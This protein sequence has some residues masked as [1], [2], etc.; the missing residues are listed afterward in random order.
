MK[1]LI[2]HVSRPS[3]AAVAVIVVTGGTAGDIHL[4]RINLPEGFT[5][6]VY[7]SGFPEARSMALGP[8]GTLFI[9]NRQDDKVWAAVD[10]NGDDRADITTV[11]L[12]GLTSPNGVAVLGND[13]YVA[14]RSRILRYRDM[15]AY[16]EKPP[17]PEVLRDD[18]PTDDLHGWKYIAFGP[19]GYLYVPVGAPCNVCLQSDGRYASITRMKPDGGDFSV[20]A[21]GIRNTVGFDW[22]PVT[23]ELWFTD[24]GRDNLGDDIPSDELNRAATAGTHF[25]F[26]FCHAGDIADPEF[27][28]QRRCDEFTPPVVNLG[29]HVAALGM[30]FY[31]GSMFPPSYRNQI[32]IAEHGS[33]NRSEK[34]GYRVVA[35]DP[36]TGKHTVFAAGWMQDEVA[37]G[38]PVDILVMPDGALLVSDDMA[39]AVYRIGYTPSTRTGS[40]FQDNHHYSGPVPQTQFSNGKNGSLVDITGRSIA[41]LNIPATTILI[42]RIS[43]KVLPPFH[44]NRNQREGL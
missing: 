7:A 44:H 5:I 14:E 8:K 16:L 3:I 4:D 30:K 33:W 27:G 15:E 13:L 17:A 23:G 19:D 24:N 35:V 2:M 41:G 22:H 34:V 37:W 10:T 28:S 20:F 21:R 38:R 26:P 32:F 1:N 42:D 36:A 40:V 6:S 18:F 39:G 11:L 43:G 29:A 31:T 25:G 9:G 12:D